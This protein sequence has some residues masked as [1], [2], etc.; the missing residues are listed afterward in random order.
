MYDF[1]YKIIKPKFKKNVE[2]CYMDTDSFVYNFK[3][4]DIYKDLTN[5][6]KHLDTS[7]YPED[8]FLYSNKNK[9]VI[10]KFK[11][12]LNGKILK[13][14]VGLRAKMYVMRTEKNIIRKAKGVKKPVVK[15]LNFNDYYKRILN[16]DEV[17]RE[18]S[19]IRSYDHKLYTITQNKVA[20]SALDD[21]RIIC[22]DGINTLAYGHYSTL[23]K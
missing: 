5:I 10:G 2:L 14:Y 1:H 22:E 3:T 11:D 21:K 20:L 17:L 8:H 12:E 19:L 15:T 23:E 13:D 18:Q 6:E 16:K 7:D 4:D 9:K